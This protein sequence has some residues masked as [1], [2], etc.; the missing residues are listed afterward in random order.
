M[1]FTEMINDLCDEI[2]A[3]AVLPKHLRPKYWARE[4]KDHI[5]FYWSMESDKS[6]FDAPVGE[7]IFLD[8]SRELVFLPPADTKGLV[9]LGKPE[10]V[11]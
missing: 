3:S 6:D 8:G 1:T 9:E 2:A 11:Q 7:K 5:E 10:E 4:H